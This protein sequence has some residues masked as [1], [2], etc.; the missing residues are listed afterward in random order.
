MLVRLAI[1]KYVKSGEMKDVPSALLAMIERNLVGCLP[2]EARHDSD[3]FRKARLYRVAV[4]H[5]LEK[6]EKWLMVSAAQ[7]SAFRQ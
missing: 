1:N 7:A 6:H 2:A 5:Q 3:V 4:A